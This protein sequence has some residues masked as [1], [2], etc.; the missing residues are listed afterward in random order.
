[1]KKEDFKKGIRF[2]LKGNYRVL[3]RVYGSLNDTLFIKKGGAHQCDVVAI[4]NDGIHVLTHVL[5][6]PTD[7]FIPFSVMELVPDERLK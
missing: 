1:M 7:T 4:M 3:Y 5:E 2:Y 6:Q